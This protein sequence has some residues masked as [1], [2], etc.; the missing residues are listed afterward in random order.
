MSIRV[1][2]R[3]GGAGAGRAGQRAVAPAARRSRGE[4]ATAR[5]GVRVRGLPAVPRRAN[6]ALARGERR[7]RAPR[8]SHG[9][10]E[11]RG[12][13]SDAGAVRPGR[14][15]A[16]AAGR[17][18]GRAEPCALTRTRRASFRSRSRPRSSPVAR[19][20]RPTA[21]S[22]RCGS[23]PPSGS[24]RTC[25]GSAPTR[26]RKRSPA[27]VRRSSHG[28]SPPTTRCRS[29][30]STTPDCKP[31][32][33]ELGIAEA[34][35]VQA[36]RM[37]QPAVCI[38]PHQARRRAQARMGA[39]LSNLRPHH[40]ALQDEHRGA[41]VRTRAG[42][43]GAQRPRRR[44]RDPDAPGSARSPP[45]ETVRYMEQVQGGGRSERGARAAHG[46]RGQ[47][48]QARRRCASRC[49]TPRRWRSSRARARPRSPSASGSRG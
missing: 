21:A 35:L 36:G 2:C 24:V 22:T 28:R 15:A 9:A 6:G 49:S 29:R 39:H 8:R 45:Q 42:R 37:R 17:R 16:R 26:T 27:E 34:D 30:S 12:R 18:R 33:A 31:S 10:R 20:S 23:S 14:A 7:G 41:A 48:Q 32:Y 38:P 1:R 4:D 19:R 44:H 46:A 11:G 3:R 25:A 5:A 40:D 47:L 13:A 43:S